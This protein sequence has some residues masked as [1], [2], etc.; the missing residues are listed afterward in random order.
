MHAAAVPR[1][2]P[3]DNLVIDGVPPIPQELA[4]RVGRYTEFRSARLLGWHPSRREILISTRFGETAQLHH[5]QRPGGARRQLTFFRDRVTT[6]FFLRGSNSIIYLRDRD[7]NEFFQIYRLDLHTSESTLLTDGKSRNTDAVGSHTGRLLAYSSTRRNGTDTDIYVVDPQDP[8]T[9][10]MLLQVSGGGWEP[11][12]WSPDDKTLLVREEIS[13]HEAYLYLVDVQSGKVTP[14]VGR[15]EGDLKKDPFGLR[16]APE[17][18]SY[19][20]ARFSADGAGV[21]VTTDRGS[22]FYRLAY[23]DLATRTHQYLTSHIQ[24]DVDS[25]DVSR[26]GSLLCFVT[27]EDGMGVLR[28][29]D[30]KARRELPRPRLPAGSVGGCT[31]HD[32]G[33][34]VAFTLATARAPLD[35]Y[36]LDVTRPDQVDRWTESEAAAPTADLPEPVLIRWKSFDGRTISGFLYRPPSRFTGPRP[37]VISIHGGP[38]AQFRPTYAGATNYLLM[39]LGVAIIYPNVR[40]STGYG[41]TFLQL[42]NGPRREDAVKDIGALLQWI[43]GRPDLDRNRVM[44][45]G[46]SYGGYMVLASSIAYGDRIRCAV[47]IVGI[48]NFVTFLERTESYRRDLRRVE[49][50]DERDPQMRALLQRISPLSHAAKIRIPLLVIQ[51]KNDPRVPYTEAEQIVQ[52]LKKQG[53][54]VW[55]L[56]ANDEGHGFAK[57]RNA[58][59]QFYTMVMFI[60]KY[61][62]G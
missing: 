27:N 41:K 2:V 46:G 45:H 5:V 59:F 31:F 48:S 60:Q 39:E 17:P 1:V 29:Y 24:W 53:T 54:P 14:L 18:V 49:Y 43:A 22:E 44:L 52:T 28:L 3:G 19:K 10:R 36:S 55:Y 12:D 25:F 30:L 61:L 8:K 4:D 16:T 40:G 42:D 6:G 26:D 9:T 57:K 58:D 20:V 21:L 50:G 13:A 47:D 32:N 7:G 37:V 11:V 23:I 62:L 33:R 38:E 15:P 51:G 56:L 34:D 35:V